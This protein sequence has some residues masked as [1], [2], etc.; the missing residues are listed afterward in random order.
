MKTFVSAAIAVGFALLSACNRNPSETESE[1]AAGLATELTQLNNNSQGNH[2]V[3]DS[4]PV[5]I[6]KFCGDCHALPKPDRFV[7]EIWYDEIEKGYEFYARSGRTDL[8]PPPLQSVLKFY[9][10][11]A[12]AQIDFPRPAEVDKELRSRFELEQIDWQDGPRLSPAISC[13]RWVNFLPEG[14]K[15][16]IVTD[17]RD[18]SVSELNPIRNHT[19]RRLIG[20]VSNPARVMACD[21]N[22]DQRTDLIVSDLGSFNPYDHGFGKVVWLTREPNSREFQLTTLVENLGRVAD[23]AVADFS[24]DRKPDILVAEFGHRLTGG[25]RL[26][27]NETENTQSWRFKETLIDIRPGTMQ[28]SAHDWNQDGEIDFASITSQEFECVDV[29]INSREKFNAYRSW[30]GGDVTFGLVGFELTDLDQD[31]DQDILCVNGDSFDN[32]FVNRS[33]G[34]QWLENVGDLKFCYHRLA[35]LPGAYRAVAVDLDGDDDLDVIVVANL[36]TDAYPRS[37]V[38]MNPVCLLML[39]Q[40]SPGNFSPKVLERGAPR[41]AALEAADFN[42]DGKIDIAV[43][44]QLFDTDPA[45]SP[46]SKLPRVTLWWQK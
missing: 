46:A 16:L 1:I 13:I 38:E 40:V 37:L 11:H 8:K 7:R 2:L 22:L 42:G 27:T 24:G 28:V 18:G 43:G 15:R 25:I 26:M 21:L 44:S 41:Y 36:P 34:V 33:H 17:M 10:E 3:D 9:R 14:E 5:A 45:G 6:S 29:Y 20:R 39:E 30:N 23:V 19:Q 12:P 32:N 35:E 4:V 31:G